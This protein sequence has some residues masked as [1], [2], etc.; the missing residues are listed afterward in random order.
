MYP[1]Y[2]SGEQPGEEPDTQSLSM[3]GLGSQLGLAHCAAINSKGKHP[4]RSHPRAKSLWR[5]EAGGGGRLRV[6]TSFSSAS[7]SILR[8]S[9]LLNWSCEV[10]IT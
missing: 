8:I 2:V 5:G 1:S 7:M 9:C 6:G 3:L 10:S 4:S